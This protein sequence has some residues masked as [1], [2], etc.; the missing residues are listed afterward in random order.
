MR[1]PSHNVCLPKPN[2]AGVYVRHRPESTLLYQIVKEYWPEF[3][4]ELANHGRH[5][6]AY[7]TKEFDEYLKCGRL[8][9]GFLRVRCEACH[10][11]KLV[12]FSCKRRGFCPSCGARRMADSAALLADEVLPH[13]PIRQWVLSVPFQLRLLFASQPA[14]MGKVLGIVY[15]SIATH[16]VHKAGFTKSTSQTGAVT[17]IQRFGSALNLNIHFHM[18]FLDGVYTGG[19][20]GCTAWFRRVKA[21]TGAELTQLAHTIAYRV[22][23]HLERQGLLVRDAQNSYLTADGLDIDPDSPMNHLLGSSVTYRIAVGPQ[24][25]R[26]VFTLQT[27]PDLGQDKPFGSA[28]SEASGFSLHAGVAT[29][30]HERE[31]LERLCRYI[32]RPAVSTERLSLTRNGRLRYELKTPWRNG[33]THVIFEP[34]DFISRLV[35]LVPKPRVNLTRFHGVFAPN[36]KHRALITPAKRGKG[37]ETSPD[38]QGEE[39]TPFEHRVAMTW[40]QRLKRVFAIDVETCS[41]CG[42]DVRVIASIEDPVVIRKILDHL[43]AKSALVR[44]CQLPLSRAPPELDLKTV[45]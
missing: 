10:D 35:S 18:L 2:S 27:L 20:N 33:T 9:H 40:A 12:A 5:L 44:S 37:R 34:L 22:A 38:K 31:K 19:A 14:V 43:E 28:V 32:A 41:E 24:Q 13:Q 25:G 4:A 8:E 36:S 3:Q 7:V 15:R 26:K 1:L 21:P 39:K 23:R 30:A 11:E 45:L 17:L 16:L 29:R 42:G 6:P